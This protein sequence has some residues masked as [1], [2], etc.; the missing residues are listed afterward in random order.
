QPFVGWTLQPVVDF[1]PAKDHAPIFATG[2]TFSD[3]YLY[4]TDLT[5]TAGPGAQLTPEATL[6]EVDS[7]EF[8]PNAAQPDGT[9]TIGLIDHRIKSHVLQVGDMIYAV[10]D[11]EVGANA[12]IRWY[13]I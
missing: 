8:P 2:L 6:I 7:Y 10:Q 4:R 11:I 12:G 9:R 13:K 5:N 3:N 1:G